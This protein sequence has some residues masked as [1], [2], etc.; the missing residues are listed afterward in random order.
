MENMYQPP[1]APLARDDKQGLVN[2]SLETGLKGEYTFKIGD[3]FREAWRLT[4]GNKGLIWG[5][6]LLAGAIV[7]GCNFLLGVLGVPDGQEQMA[8][9]EWFT[10]YGLS[11]LKGFI[12]TPISAPIMTGFFLVCIKRTA[13][14]PV[15]ISELF[16]YFKL[17]PNLVILSI[18]S[19]VLLYIGLALFVLPG[20][21][22]MV[23]YAF[24]MPL[25]VEKKLSPWQA[26][27]ASRRAVTHHWFS[28]FGVGALLYLTF[29]VSMIT[30][31]GPIWVLPMSMI[32]YSL[33]YI[34][35][36]G[37]KDSGVDNADST[38]NI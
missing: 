2:G 36:F 26:L 1:N 23:A 20:I 24:A 33:V 15:E 14:V 32:G 37:I 3:I 9:G 25:M 13:N 31:I 4:K 29:I 7:M 38:E 27:E 35:I 18:M 30:V 34:T 21:Y 11:L 6:T 8:A 5:A 22:L 16:A 17:V 19:T 28:V 12:L 10:G